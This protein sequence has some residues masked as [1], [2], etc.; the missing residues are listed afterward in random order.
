MDFGR[1]KLAR[2]HGLQNFRGMGKGEGESETSFNKAAK[3]LRVEGVL[4]LTG[5]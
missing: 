2:T 3:G 4:F 1:R 5:K